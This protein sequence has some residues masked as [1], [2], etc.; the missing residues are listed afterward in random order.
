L[1]HPY[2][3]RSVLAKIF[4]N[5]TT[6]SNVFAVWVTVGFFEVKDETTRPVKLGAEIG[7]SENRHLRHRFFAIVD[8]SDLRAAT[9]TSSAAVSPPAGGT[10]TLTLSSQYTTVTGT[11]QT[12]QQGDVISID[13]NT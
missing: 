13:P 4:N 8:R 3:R 11:Q 5:V 10:A 2:Q 9:F 6:R 12:W 1:T 7:R